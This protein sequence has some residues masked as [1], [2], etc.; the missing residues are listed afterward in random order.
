VLIRRRS[1][2][3]SVIS[4]AAAFSSKYLRRLVP[5]IGP[6]SSPC[7]STQASASCEGSQPLAQ[8]ISSTYRDR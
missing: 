3:V 7:A 6:M 5:G 2:G 8:A 1:S 4:R